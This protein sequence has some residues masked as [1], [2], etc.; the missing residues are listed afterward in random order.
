MFLWL[1]FKLWSEPFKTKFWWNFGLNEKWFS[2]SILY[3]EY[4]NLLRCWIEIYLLM[5]IYYWKERKLLRFL[6]IRLLSF[7]M[8][9][10]LED[11][12]TYPRCS[13]LLSFNIAQSTGFIKYFHER[14]NQH[15][16]KGKEQEV[17]KR[18]TKPLTLPCRHVNANCS[19]YY[20]SQL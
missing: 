3:I 10:N 17:S 2:S 7:S 14:R 16:S 9:L 18:K 4:K 5:S 19:K 20:W 15:I 13:N 11:I 6:E 8:S 12:L 1:Q